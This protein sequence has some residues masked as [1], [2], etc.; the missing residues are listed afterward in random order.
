MRGQYKKFLTH[1]NYHRVAENR[2]EWNRLQE[3]FALYGPG[4]GESNGRLVVKFK[5]YRRN[6]LR[7]IISNSL[8][9]IDKSE[10]SD[11]YRLVM[12]FLTALVF[13][14]KYY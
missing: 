6:Q 4:V 1:K 8:S 3:T 5:K 7:W 9:I 12:I 11:N 13:T 14:L 2:K 10:L